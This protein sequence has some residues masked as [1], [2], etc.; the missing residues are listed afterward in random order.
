MMA[1]RPRSR[2]RTVIV[3][4]FYLDLALLYDHF[5]LLF[6]SVYRRNLE[7]CASRAKHFPIAPTSYSVSIKIQNYASY[8]TISLLDKLHT[9]CIYSQSSTPTRPLSNITFASAQEYSLPHSVTLK[10]PRSLY[11]VTKKAPIQS[12]VS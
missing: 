11:I 4:R 3:L 8:L 6:V 1:P 10:F 5:S 2:R 7:I 9:D 12:V